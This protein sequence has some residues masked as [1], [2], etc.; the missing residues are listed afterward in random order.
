[1]SHPVKSL[2]DEVEGA[3][4]SRE[5]KSDIVKEE[6]DEFGSDDHQPVEVGQESFGA[7][8]DDEVEYV[9]G[10]PVIRSG[11]CP[12][13]SHFAATANDFDEV[14]MSPNSSCLPETMEIHRWLSG[15]SFWVA[16]LRRYPA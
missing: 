12:Q 9:G 16:Y 13:R 2:N 15:L 10:H 6:P 4:F 8:P 5:V 7:P 14:L 3:Q 11:N 1:M